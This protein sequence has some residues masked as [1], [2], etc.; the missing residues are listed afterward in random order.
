MVK[1]KENKQIVG[2]LQTIET[3]RISLSVISLLILVCLCGATNAYA[4]SRLT[5]IKGA[6]FYGNNML[7]DYDLQINNLLLPHHYNFAYIVR[8]SFEAEYSLAGID[9]GTLILRKAEIQIW[10]PAKS[11][12]ITIIEDS[13]QLSSIVV[14]S[15]SQMMKFA[16]LSSSYLADD[17]MGFDGTTYDFISWPY[18]AECWTP[19]D[20]SNCGELVAFADSICKAVELHDST[21]IYSCLNRLTEL[22]HSFKTLYDNTPTEKDLQKLKNDKNKSVPFQGYHLKV[23]LLI[24]SLFFVFIGVV[25]S[26]TLLCSKRRKYWWIPLLLAFIACI[27]V[28][29]VSY[30]YIIVNSLSC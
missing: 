12:K 16:V 8:P 22:Y 19:E 26:I 13:L 3:R 11:K 18:T 25:C 30:L 4:Q 15:I 6:I 27:V 29:G 23:I 2:L 17:R 14:D 21:L 10:P 5:P 9:G 28:G 24:S 20:N 7:N 1:R